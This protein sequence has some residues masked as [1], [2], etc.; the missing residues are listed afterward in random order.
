[1]A[2]TTRQGTTADLR[3]CPS[4]ACLED[5]ILVRRI[6]GLPQEAVLNHSDV[7]DAIAFWRPEA[8]QADGYIGVG[9]EGSRP[10]DV[11]LSVVIH[12][13]LHKAL[14]PEVRL[15]VGNREKPVLIQ[16]ICEGI[17]HWLGP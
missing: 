9:C 4:P 13:D 14:F 15:W 17:G 2:L 10:L 12:G 6:F 11:V 16:L 1:M 8:I 3:D 5:R 7:V